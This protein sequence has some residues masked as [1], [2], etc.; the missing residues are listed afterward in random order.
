[1]TLQQTRQLGIEFERRLHEIYPDFEIKEKLDTDTIYSFLSEYQ[2]KYVKE[3]YLSESQVEAGSRGSKRVN[4]AI[5]TLIRHKTISVDDKNIDAD[6]KTSI[7][8]IPKDYFLY[9]RSN[10]IIN[11]NYK[12]RERLSTE[13][14]TPNVA[15]RQDDVENVVGTFYNNNAIIRNPLVILESVDKDSPYIKVVHDNYTNIVALDLVYCC[16]PYAFNVTGY[17]DDD[18]SESAVHSC[19]EL[20][21]SCF[22]DILVGA[23][24]LYVSNYKFKLA[25]A[26][27]GDRQNRRRNSRENTEDR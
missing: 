14:H 4:D 12:Q 10:S 8:K 24:D 1:M 21:F 25:L 16:Y 19:C 3:I 9:I 11:K 5:K 22:D 2:M 26:A 15:I 27:N 18:M 7:F 20:P 17:N 6:D 13:V 23:I